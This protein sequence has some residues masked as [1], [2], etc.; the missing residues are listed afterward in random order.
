[1]APSF[2]SYRIVHYIW[3]TG[4][5]HCMRRGRISHDLPLGHLWSIARTA[6]NGA[7]DCAVQNFRL[8]F[9][10]SVILP[11]TCDVSPPGPAYTR[12]S[13]VTESHLAEPSI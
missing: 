13:G 6:S 4:K 1:M 2:V 3:R 7:K 11:N 5:I 12:V 9:L 8:A 10:T